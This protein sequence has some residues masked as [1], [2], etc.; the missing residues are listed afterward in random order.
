ME[1]VLVAVNQSPDITDRLVGITSDIG[2][3]TRD[4]ATARLPAGGMLFIGTPDGQSVAPG[5]LDANNAAKATVALT[6]PITNGL[7]LQLHLQFRE[8]RAGQ[9]EGADFGRGGAARGPN[10]GAAA[11]TP[12]CCRTRPL[13]SPR[14][15]ARSQYRCSECR[16]VTAKWVGRC[17]ECGTWGTVD[18]VA[19]LSAVGAAAARGLNPAPAVPINSIEPNSAG[20]APPAST[21]STGCSAAAWYP[22]R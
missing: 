7:D 22:A 6:K 14:G 13:P 21:N 20:T 16:H 10:R 8:G 12:G 5:P 17:L 4:R 2:T 1:L 9:R 15:Q 11:C 3:V 18:E 19:V